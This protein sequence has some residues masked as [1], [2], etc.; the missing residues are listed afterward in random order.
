MILEESKRLSINNKIVFDFQKDSG[1]SWEGLNYSGDT[2]TVY[3]ILMPFGGREIR[4]LLIDSQFGRDTLLTGRFIFGRH[5]RWIYR[6]CCA[7]TAK[8]LQQFFPDVLGYIEH[9]R[10][11]LIL[12]AGEVMALSPFIEG[13]KSQGNDFKRHP[14]AGS[15][16]YQAK[17]TSE[18]NWGKATTRIF[19]D[20]CPASG[21]TMEAFVKKALKESNLKR[22][23]FNCSTSTINALN[24]V[25]PLIPSSVEVTVIYWEALFS[26]WRKDVVLPDGEVINGGTIINLNPDHEAPEN[27]PIAP[28]EVVE[29]IHKVF[30][31]DNVNLLPDIPGEVGEKIQDN[32]LGPILYDILEFYNAGINL[33][34]EPWRS[35]MKKVWEQPEVQISLEEK[36]PYIYDNIKAMMSDKTYNNDK[37]ETIESENRHLVLL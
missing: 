27:N 31:R 7:T 8:I 29:L 35:K 10:E 36:L 19:S 6:S 22:I 4:L 20:I 34:K 15:E 18:I 11:H 5:A 17:S 24:R 33:S 9:A 21:G 37:I 14:V 16:L 30:Q 28:Q 1:L 26:V 12:R 2:G 32:Q 25:M 13:L 23:I 3:D